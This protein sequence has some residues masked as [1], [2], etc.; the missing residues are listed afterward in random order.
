M[1]YFMTGTIDKYVLLNTNSADE[2]LLILYVLVV[3]ML[4]FTRLGHK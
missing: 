4:L 1:V 3:D 2:V